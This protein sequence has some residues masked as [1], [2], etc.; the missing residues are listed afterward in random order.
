MSLNSQDIVQQVESQL[1][2]HPNATLQITAKKLGITE[3]LITD[4]LREVEGVSFQEFRAGKRLEQAFGQLNEFSIASNGPSERRARRR[5]IIPKA[6]VK[7]SI[8]SFW[9]FRS[10]YSSQ[11]PL[12]DFG[13][14]GLALLADESVEPQKRISLVL[15]FP[16][17]EKTIQIE[18]TVAYSVA[19]GIAGYRYRIGIQFLPFDKRKGGNTPRVLETLTRI[20]KT[21]PK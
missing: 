4:A 12:V 11:C 6:T 19:T 15:K 5:S 2:A 1:K 7:Y 14:D 20:E 17:E 3:Q 9:R 16:G 18:G 13:S 21:Y 10:A 8:H